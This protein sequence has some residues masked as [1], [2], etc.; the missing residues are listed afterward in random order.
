MPIPAGP[1][2]HLALV[3]PDLLLGQLESM[4]DRQRAPA[5]PHDPLQAAGDGPE[6]EGEG[7]LIRV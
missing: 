7:D 3:E 5:A 2:A 4:F 1:V 6:D